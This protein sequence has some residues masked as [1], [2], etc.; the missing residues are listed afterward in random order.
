MDN[1]KKNLRV[2]KLQEENKV[3]K[4]ENTSMINNGGFCGDYDTSMCANAMACRLKDELVKETLD[5]R[6]ENIKLKEEKLER[7]EHIKMADKK[8]LSY[9]II[10][11]DL[12]NIIKDNEI[13]S[14]EDE[15]E[16]DKSTY[17]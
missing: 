15:L 2:A 17:S 13:S 16:E 4:E 14:D 11:T 3:L 6:K 12:A 1:L 10:L 9:Q 5:L 8:I 7:D